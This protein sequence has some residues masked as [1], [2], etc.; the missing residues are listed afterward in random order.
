MYKNGVK[1]IEELAVKYNVELK[2]EE[3]AAIEK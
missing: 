2:P 3:K 1:S